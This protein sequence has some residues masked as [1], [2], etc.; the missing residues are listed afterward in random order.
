MK[1]ILTVL[2]CL[3]Y[4]TW[5][6]TPAQRVAFRTANSG[7]S[8]FTEISSSFLIAGTATVLAFMW[9]SWVFISAYRAWGKNKLSFEEAG[10][11]ALRA[12]FVFIVTLVMVAY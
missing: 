3:P 4:T 12:L 10:S 5:A 6:M 11:Q 1:Y 7:G 8:A 9:V 2:F